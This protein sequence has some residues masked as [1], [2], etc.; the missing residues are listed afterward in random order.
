MRTTR[1]PSSSVKRDRFLDHDPFT[2]VER[3]QRLF[4]VVTAGRADRDQIDVIPPHQLAIIGVP[5]DAEVLRNR[6]PS[7]HRD[8]GCIRKRLQRLQMRAANVPEPDDADANRAIQLIA[9]RL[10]VRL[11]ATTV[12]P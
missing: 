2:G 10:I 1:S 11:H 7:R 8:D 5:G 6:L 4:R 9:C 12:S 3:G